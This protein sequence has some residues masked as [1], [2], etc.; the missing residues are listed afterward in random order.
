[1]HTRGIPPLLH[2]MLHG[3]V[4]RMVYPTVSSWT[5]DNLCGKVPNQI[6][7]TYIY[8]HIY[9]FH[10]QTARKRIMCDLRMCHII[11]NKRKCKRA[12][13]KRFAVISYKQGLGCIQLYK[14]SSGT[15]CSL[16]CFSSCH[17][18]NYV[19]FYVIVRN[20]LTLT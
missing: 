4:N 19:H 15:I 20:L 10:I 18:L 3:P 14:V 11:Y 5:Y 1:M 6:C 12:F 8:I 17:N 7:M 13:L 2:K 9:R 16:P